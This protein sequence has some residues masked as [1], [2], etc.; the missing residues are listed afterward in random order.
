M[1]NPGINKRY[2][3]ITISGRAAN[4]ATTLSRHL[5]RFLGWKLINAG[6]LVREYV[7]KKGIPLEKTGLTEDKYHLDL[8]NFIR[9]KLKKE[10]KLIIE[11]WLSGYDAK[12]IPGVFKIFVLCSDDEIRVKRIMERDR[13]SYV[14]AKSHLQTREK[15]NL[16]KWSKLYG[17]KDFW[18]EKLYDLVIDTKNKD[19]NASLALTL[20]ALEK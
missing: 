10:K 4:G 11:S 6:E 15:E 7:K 16:K 9:D 17:T 2:R 1:E 18:D 20:E 3:N 14:E 8:D 19:V 12:N 13:M 5:A